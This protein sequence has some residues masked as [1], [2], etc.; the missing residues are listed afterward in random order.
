MCLIL[1]G[2]VCLVLTSEKKYYEQMILTRILQ[3]ICSILS[4]IFYQGLLVNVYFSGCLILYKIQQPFDLLIRTIYIK[5]LNKT[6]FHSEKIITKIFF[7]RLTSQN[8]CLSNDL[9]FH[10]SMKYSEDDN[11]L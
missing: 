11:K 5:N 6:Y 8:I 10:V 3:Y 7:S 9:L 4:T 2:S 1:S